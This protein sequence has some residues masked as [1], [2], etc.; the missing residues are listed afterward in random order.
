M[1]SHI[2][3]EGN[4]FACRAAKDATKERNLY[5]LPLNIDEYNSIIKKRIFRSWQNEW[6]AMNSHPC[7]PCHLYKIKPKLGDWKSSYKENRREEVVLS[8][9]RTG[10]CRY[11][12]QHYFQKPD[13]VPMNKCNY[14]SVTNTIAHLI[15]DCPRWGAY[16]HRMYNHIL[17]LKLPMNLNSILGEK[18]DHSILFSYLRSINYFDHI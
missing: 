12:V 2:D 9:L 8:R 4:D 7:Q 16:R 3:I 17:R 5:R 18:F 11:F 1:P 13:L 10:T 6:T 14:C 15:L